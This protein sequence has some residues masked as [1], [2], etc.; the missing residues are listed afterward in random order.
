MSGAVTCNIG[1]LPVVPHTG[2][3]YIG[4]ITAKVT[5]AASSTVTNTIQINGLNPDP[6]TKNNSVSVSIKVTR[7]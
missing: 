4:Q 6:N 3:I 7:S 1:N 2:S 5:A